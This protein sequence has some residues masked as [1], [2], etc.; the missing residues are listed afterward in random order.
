M[1]ISA[2][3]LAVDGP[4]TPNLRWASARESI[5]RDFIRSAIPRTAFELV[6]II[7]SYLDTFRS[8][9]SSGS[10]SRAGTISMVGYSNTSAPRSSSCFTS[11]LACDRARVTSIRLPNRGR[12]SNHAISSRRPA[13]SPMT[14]QTG[15]PIPA[16]RPRATISPIGPVT[17][18]CFA[19]VPH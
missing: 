8:A 2:R 4:L 7:Q 5:P 6:N 13:T 16:S 11:L 17:T 19:V 18:R 1:P 3:A 12:V 14:R 15:A 10:V 9:W